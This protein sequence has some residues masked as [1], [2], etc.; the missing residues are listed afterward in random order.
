MMQ[1]WLQRLLVGSVLILGLLSQAQVLARSS[2]ASSKS[3]VPDAPGDYHVEIRTDLGAEHSDLTNEPSLAPAGTSILETWNVYAAIST[4]AGATWSYRDPVQLFGNEYGGFTGDQVAIY[5]PGSNLIFWFLLYFP[6]LQQN[7]AMKAAWIPAD[8]LGTDH[9]C[10]FDLIPRYLGAQPG[11]YIDMPKIGLTNSYLWLAADI[12]GADNFSAVAQMDVASF[13]PFPWPDCYPS[14]N[15]QYLKID[16]ALSDPGPGLIVRGGDRMWFATHNK[17][18]DSLLRVWNW[19]QGVGFQGA[20]YQDVTH[21]SYPNFPHD[22]SFTGKGGGEETNWCKHDDERVVTGWLSGETL[23][24]IWDASQDEFL[25]PHPFPYVHVL[26]MLITGVPPY[27]LT[28]IDEPNL[29]SPEN[30]FAY[31]AGSVNARGGVGGTVMF[32]GG[33]WWENC[34]TFLWDEYNLFPWEVHPEFLS[35]V[36]PST[37]GGDYLASRAN[38]QNPNTWSATCYTLQS[39][40]PSIAAHPWYVWFGRKIDFP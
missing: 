10:A 12:Y 29:W 23:T 19:P 7:N 33:Y 8:Q 11:S 22:C 38:G 18:A 40:G 35:T 27:I 26:R 37:L 16:P 34:A 24:F 2:Q 17:T 31:A 28:R 25:T 15:V 9:W 3:N 14:V 30:A 4:N 32:G 39:A 5:D 6:D 36:A 13:L 1:S 20:H 21:L